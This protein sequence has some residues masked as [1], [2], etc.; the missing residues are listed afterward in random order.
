MQESGET[1]SISRLR[2]IAWWL[3]Q[4][5]LCVLV[6]GVIVVMFASIAEVWIK[7]EVAE[8]DSF[9][10][11]N[12]GNFIRM[13]GPIS[14][15]SEAVLPEW[16]IRLPCLALVVRE[17]TEDYYKETFSDAVSISVKK[18]PCRLRHV[19]GCL[20]PKELRPLPKDAVQ[21]LPQG[22]EAVRWGESDGRTVLEGTRDGS[23]VRVEF[24]YVPAE[25]SRPLCLEGIQRADGLEFPRVVYPDEPNEIRRANELSVYGY[26]CVHAALLL[27]L[28]GLFYLLVKPLRRRGMRV[29]WGLSL[30][31]WAGCGVCVCMLLAILVSSRA[32]EYMAQLLARQALSAERIL[33]E[34]EG[35]RV[36]VEGE[37]TSSVM[38]EATEWDFSKQALQVSATSDTPIR[39]ELVICGTRRTQLGAFNFV[40]APA[41]ASSPAEAEQGAPIGWQEI[42][43]RVKEQGLF[44]EHMMYE[45]HRSD[46]LSMRVY[47]EG[48]QRGNT[49]LAESWGKQEPYHTWEGYY[50]LGI[51][52][53]YAAQLCLAAG[54]VLALAHLVCLLFGKLLHSKQDES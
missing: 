29:L 31:A 9:L 16:G 6:I 18:T 2:R 11:E 25:I 5:L 35:K 47:A 27:L 8:T 13:Q 1:N 30:S 45:R 12:S 48:V 24:S 38:L 10:P 52:N 42:E 17:T 7:N 3:K 4:G 49:L 46:I 22:L 34:N 53:A 36:R 41:A 40:A 43:R 54:V 33:P 37:L 19:S 15:E 50:F 39:H 14:T 21:S 51:L 28:V 23:P 44:P 20:L 32:Q 26:V